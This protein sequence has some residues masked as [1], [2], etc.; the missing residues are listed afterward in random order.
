M[1]AMPDPAVMT[2]C[3]LAGI[4]YG[5]LGSFC[6]ARNQALLGDVI[7]HAAW[8]GLV[9]AL[10][11]TGSRHFGVLGVGA[12]L[13]G[14]MALFT[15]E[16]L[17]RGSTR[18]KPDTRLALVL[19][20][21]FAAGMLF[22]RQVQTSRPGS[23]G[24]LHSFLFG[25][26]AALVWMDT[27]VMAAVL[28]PTMILVWIRWR[29]LSALCF[30]PQWRQTT[31]HANGATPAILNGLLV[32]GIVAGLPVAGVVLVSALLVCLPVTARSMTN[33]FSSGILVAMGLGAALGA[34]SPL[35]VMLTESLFRHWRGNDDARLP[36]GPVFVLLGVT[37]SGLCLG[38]KTLRQRQ[39]QRTGRH[40]A[41][42]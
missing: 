31:P 5:L 16:Y 10:G 41:S 18:I 22:T 7:S 15:L 21:F 34:L 37:C 23:M 38:L 6:M 40:H 29:D 2:G 1:S 17:G 30:D 36:T 27:A 11:L 39:I 8:P 32:V 4:L 9:L 14:L 13:V 35:V 19:S 42:C 20:G 25:Q 33:R 12:A 26:T 28:I 3:I 24:H